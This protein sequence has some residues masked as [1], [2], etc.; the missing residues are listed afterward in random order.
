[1]VLRQGMSPV[2]LGLVLGLAAAVAADDRP[3]LHAAD[4][5]AAG[6]GIVDA[7]V[8]RFVAAEG[9]ERIAD[10]LAYGGPSIATRK[11]T[12]CSARRP[13]TGTGEWCTSRA[14]APVR[15]FCRR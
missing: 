5:I 3:A 12:F 8:A 14:T 1:M 15:P 6:A 10:L 13:R 7:E 9:P 4:T 2:A 11:A